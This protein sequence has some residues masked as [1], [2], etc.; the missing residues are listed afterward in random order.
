MKKKKPVLSLREKSKYRVA[1]RLEVKAKNS[2]YVT[3]LN[4]T[5]SM[6]LG[7]NVLRITDNNRTCK[8]KS[9]SIN[10]EKTAGNLEF[11]LVLCFKCKSKPILFHIDLSTAF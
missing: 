7:H 1:E 11:N 9:K 3:Y 6:V 8:P 4:I 5:G 10:A 2:K